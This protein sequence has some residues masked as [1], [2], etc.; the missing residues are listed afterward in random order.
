MREKERFLYGWLS[1]WFSHLDLGAVSVSVITFGV[2]TLISSLRK[3]NLATSLWNRFPQLFMHASRT[4]KA[5]NEN[6][7]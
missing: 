7:S 4:W 2:K 5:P 3:R 1:D 6:I